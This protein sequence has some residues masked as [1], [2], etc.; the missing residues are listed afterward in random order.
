M[1]YS[2]HERRAIATLAKVQGSKRDAAL[3]AGIDPAAFQRWVGGQPAVADVHLVRLRIQ[4]GLLPDGPPAPNPERMHIWVPKRRAKEVEVDAALELFFPEPPEVAE[5]PWSRLGLLRLKKMA[6]IDLR[7]EVYA[8]FDRRIMVV[9]RPA[10][11]IGVATER[12]N[13][14]WRGGSREAAVLDPPALE[15]LLK[16]E[17]TPEE[18][19][20]AW[21][22]PRKAISQADEGQPS[23]FDWK[24]EPSETGRTLEDLDAMVRAFGL[25]YDEAIDAIRRLKRD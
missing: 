11:G 2:L 24:Q 20:Q 7:P 1:D 6:L 25:S 15:L 19:R 13:C 18:F 16:D 10:V 14:K 3:K 4:L 21:F 8:F 17:P 23:S 9:F 12:L 22:G 5:A